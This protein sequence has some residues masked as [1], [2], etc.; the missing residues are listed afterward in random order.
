MK[1]LKDD[2]IYIDLL[3]YL[4][5]AK[6]IHVYINLKLHFDFFEVGKIK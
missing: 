2:E 5:F 1:L 3:G 4:D 6:S